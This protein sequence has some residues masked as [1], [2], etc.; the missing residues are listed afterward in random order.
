MAFRRNGKDPERIWRAENRQQLIDA[1]IPVY[2]VDD[3]RRWNYVLLHGDDALDSGWSTN[4]LE[5]EQCQGLVEIISTFYE[6][7]TGLDLCA[8]LRR[9]L[10]TGV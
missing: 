5:R 4:D 10:E 6:N 8:D 1:G 7:E 9:R 3:E 2:L